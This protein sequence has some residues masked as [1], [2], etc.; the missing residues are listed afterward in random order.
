MDPSALLPLAPR[1]HTHDGLC[2]MAEMGEMGMPVPHN[3][4]PMVGQR[5]KH[6]Y[7][8]MGGMFTVLKVRD[9][10]DSYEDPGWYE[11]RRRGERE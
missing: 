2:G 5:G 6:D 3:S 1:A 10:L 11:A 8:T 4:I 9:R 7:I